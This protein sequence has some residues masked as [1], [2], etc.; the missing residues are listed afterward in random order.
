MLIT[1]VFCD[2]FNLFI[3][4][5]TE[6][7]YFKRFCAYMYFLISGSTHLNLRW[8][9]SVHLVFSLNKFYKL[10]CSNHLHHVL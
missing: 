2:A 5:Y 8:E 3:S 10:F 1:L 7:S 6:W 9:D 4:V